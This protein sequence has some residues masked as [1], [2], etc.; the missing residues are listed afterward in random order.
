MESNSE[1]NHVS[2]FFLFADFVSKF[3]QNF[4]YHLTPSLHHL[5]KIAVIL[6]TIFLM[7]C[8]RSFMFLIG[9]GW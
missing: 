6:M 5:S 1:P 8:L 4:D 9:G 2:F 7:G 3:E